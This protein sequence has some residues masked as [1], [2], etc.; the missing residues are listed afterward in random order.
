MILIFFMKQFEGNASVS[1]VNFI[2]TS[3]NQLKS[4]CSFDSKMNRIDCDSLSFES[5]NKIDFKCKAILDQ[6]HLNDSASAS[7]TLRIDM[8]QSIWSQNNGINFNSI[9]F[10]FN[11]LELFNLKGFEIDEKSVASYFGSNIIG[12]ERHKIKWKMIIKMK[13]Q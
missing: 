11:T 10:A 4:F 7:L 1:E 5:L 9:D 6:H 3:N 13:S 2:E 8:K 12:M